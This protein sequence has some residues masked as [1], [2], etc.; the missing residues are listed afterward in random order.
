MKNEGVANVQ[1]VGYDSLLAVPLPRR[2][3]RTFAVTFD[4][5][6]PGGKKL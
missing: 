1:A 2:L 6:P 5:A 4:A 3:G